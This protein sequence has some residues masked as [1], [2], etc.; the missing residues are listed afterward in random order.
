MQ[1][2]NPRDIHVRVGATDTVAAR[3]R[4]CQPRAY[5]AASQFPFELCDRGEDAEDESAGV[6]V[7]QP[8]Q[9]RQIL[10]HTGVTH[11]GFGT[12]P[13]ARCHGL[14]C[15][16]ALRTPPLGMRN[17]S[18][19]YQRSQYS[20]SPW[21]LARLVGEETGHPTRCQLRGEREMKWTVRGLGRDDPALRQLR[22]TTIAS[23]QT[24]ICATS[25]RGTSPPATFGGP[26]YRRFFSR[27]VCIPNHQSVN[28]IAR[29]S[30]KAN[31]L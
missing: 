2:D 10:R 24:K 28:T 23:A 5:P 29:I 4:C 6:E 20:R 18:K 13:L 8:W 9:R 26:G 15:A 1:L 14:S 11:R 21:N 31:P 3:L 22:D 19:A 12:V 16:R 17:L 25:P 27:F 30:G 7:C